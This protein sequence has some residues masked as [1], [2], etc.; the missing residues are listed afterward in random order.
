MFKV[1]DLDK[2]KYLEPAQLEKIFKIKCHLV[3]FETA[4]KTLKDRIERESEELGLNFLCRI[5]AGGI[6]IM[7]DR[8][9]LY[10]KKR[11]A[12]AKYKSLAKNRLDMNKIDPTNLSKDDQ[13]LLIA[14]K[15]FQSQVINMIDNLLQTRAPKKT[16]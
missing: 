13:G 10:Y 9:A 2:G 3:A 14:E 12:R 5:D 8:E 1:E 15:G 6:K 16:E 4:R 11:I 7:E